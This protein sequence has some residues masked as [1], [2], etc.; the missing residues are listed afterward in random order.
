MTLKDKL[1]QQCLEIFKREEVKNELKSIMKPV[2]D[3]IL[4]E[5]YPYIYLSLIFVFISFFLILG[6]FIL[7]VKN[8]K[9]LQHIQ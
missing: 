7:L 1:I 8:Q 5:L 3:M 2:I 4:I 6:I 9:N